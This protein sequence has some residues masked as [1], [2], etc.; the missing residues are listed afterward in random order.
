MGVLEDKGLVGLAKIAIRNKEQLCALRPQD[1][2]LILETLYYPDEIR[3]EKSVEASEVKVSE[4]EMEM[5]KTL[6]NVLAA[7]FEPEKYQDEYRQALMELIEAK[8][9][10]HEVV[11]P[12]PPRGKVVDLMAALRQSVEAARKRR[13]EE[14]ERQRRKAS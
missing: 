10:G 2:T 13:P 11:A 14:P 5:A 4:Q 12:P 1:G 6:V 8:R 9:K 7:R 3:V